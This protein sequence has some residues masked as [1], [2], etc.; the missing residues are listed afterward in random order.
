MEK[1]YKPKALEFMHGRLLEE[2]HNWRTSKGT[3][4][5]IMISGTML[6]DLIAKAKLA[7]YEHYPEL[8]QEEQV[9]IICPDCDGTGTRIEIGIE[10]TCCQRPNEDGSCCGI[11]ELK[12]AKKQQPC[13][14]C[15]QTGRIPKV[16]KEL[17]P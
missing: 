13:E 8:K 12:V 5:H 16:T 6:N 3:N 10:P 1:D 14:R 7:T 4:V 15:V 17:R 9:F 2:F 11:Q